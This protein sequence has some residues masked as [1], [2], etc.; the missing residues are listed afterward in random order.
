MQF[1]LDCGVEE[2]MSLPG[3]TVGIGILV[4]ANMHIEGTLSMQYAAW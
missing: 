2:M 3:D 4:K 1:G